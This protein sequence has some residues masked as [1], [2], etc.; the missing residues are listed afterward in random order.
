MSLRV[1]ISL[2]ANA[3]R[4]YQLIRLQKLS[5]IKKGDITT[6]QGIFLIPWTGGSFAPLGPFLC[7]TTEE[8]KWPIAPK[9]GP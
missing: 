8:R 7:H 3:L 1:C 6:H 4:N 2:S 9:P 5:L